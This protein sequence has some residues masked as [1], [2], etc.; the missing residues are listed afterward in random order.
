MKLWL[1]CRG[2]I[3]PKDTTRSFVKCPLLHVP[4]TLTVVFEE[5]PVMYTHVTNIDIPVSVTDAMTRLMA[6]LVDCLADTVDVELMEDVH[7]SLSRTVALQHHW[8]DPFTTDLRRGLDAEIPEFDLS[9]DGV[10]LL[11]NDEK[12]R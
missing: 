5:Q 3:E 2:S 11:T 9:F 4:K 10:K 8:I 6:D 1:F 7:I 12:T